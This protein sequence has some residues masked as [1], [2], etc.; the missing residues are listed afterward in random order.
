MKSAVNAVTNGSK[1]RDTQGRLRTSVIKVDDGMIRLEDLL[2]LQFNT[3][4]S[5]ASKIHQCVVVDKSNG[6]HRAFIVHFE[7]TE[8]VHGVDELREQQPLDEVTPKHQ[9]RRSQDAKEEEVN[10]YGN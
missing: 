8:L 5:P 1:I 6:T 4:I 7:L 3:S 9:R 10:E 2:Y